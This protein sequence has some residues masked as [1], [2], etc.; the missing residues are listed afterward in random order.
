MEDMYEKE[1]DKE[2]DGEG[3][4]VRADLQGLYGI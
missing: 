4:K 3:C 1:K 2:T